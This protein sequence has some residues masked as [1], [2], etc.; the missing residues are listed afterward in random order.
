FREATAG[1]R[2]HDRLKVGWKDL[3]GRIE[4]G[5]TREGYRIRFY[6]ITSDPSGPLPKRVSDAPSLQVL[7]VSVR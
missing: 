2:R 5:S 4:N 3:P 1:R 7:I 6:L